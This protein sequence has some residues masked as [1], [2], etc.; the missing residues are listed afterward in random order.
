MKHRVPYFDW[1]FWG[2][3]KKSILY[4]TV[5]FEVIKINDQ[6]FGLKQSVQLLTATTF[7]IGDAEPLVKLKE[8]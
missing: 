5:S 6:K 7:N 4:S 3:G 8:K 2:Q 1:K